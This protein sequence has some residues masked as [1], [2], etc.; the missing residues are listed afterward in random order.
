MTSLNRWFYKP[1]G[2]AVAESIAKQSD[3]S[4]FS[5]SNSCLQIGVE[6]PILRK[7]MMVLMPESGGDVVSSLDA[8]PF[9][10]ESFSMVFLPFT[11]EKLANIAGLLDEI[12]RILTFDGYLF[13]V[14]M[15]PWSLWGLSRLLSKKMVWSGD[16]YWRS[17]LRLY[18]Q[19]LMRGFRI[20]WI[21]SFFFRP[22]LVS[23]ESLRKLRFLEPIGNIVWPYPGALY[24]LVAQKRTVQFLTVDQKIGGYTFEKA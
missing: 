13:I 4:G 19:L 6:V 12:D 22:P 11:F 10:N 18:S 7:K 24:F 23:K 2:R 8:L 14:G 3:I 20:H 9:Q 17:S 1:L 5:C 16:I 21:K 15:N